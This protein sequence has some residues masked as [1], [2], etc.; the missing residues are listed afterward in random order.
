MYVQNLRKFSS[1]VPRDC[2]ELR[3]RHVLPQRK[4]EDPAVPKGGGERCKEYN[5]KMKQVGVQIYLPV[6]LPMMFISTFISFSEGI[7][8][9]QTEQPNRRFR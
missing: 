5:D 6:T 7:M 8:R 4:T 9:K 2:E 3:A 1:W